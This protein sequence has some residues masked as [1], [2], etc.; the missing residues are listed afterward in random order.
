MI[1]S[2]EQPF[3]LEVDASAFA[4]GAVL[5]QQDERGSRLHVGYFSKTLNK[6]ERNYDFWDGEFIEVI[7]ALRNWRHL[8]QGSPHKVVVLTDYSIIV[9]RKKSTAGWPDVSQYW[10]TSMWI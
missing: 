7:L 1:L 9:T 2:A 5:I 10:Q 8:L 3:K 4:V 6:T